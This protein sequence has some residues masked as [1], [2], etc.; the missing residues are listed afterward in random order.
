[1]IMEKALVVG[2]SGLLGGHLI[3]AAKNEYEVIATFKDHP[4]EIGGCR[5]VCLDITDRNKTEKVIIKEKPDLIILTAAQ[6]NVDY[7]EK[8]PDEAGKVNAEGA[9]NV[10]VAS[11]KVHAK[12]IYLSTDLVFDG[13]KT[14]YVEDDETHPV[15]HYGRTKL[16]GE[17]E[18]MNACKDAAIARVSVLYGWNIFDHTFNFVAWVY[19]NLKQ[20]KKLELFEDQFRNATYVKNACHALLNIYKNDEKG[21]YHVVGKN[22]VNRYYIGMKV[23]EIFEL[24]ENL[25]TSCDSDESDW[26]AKR[27]KRCCLDPEKMEKKLDIESMSLEEGLSAMRAEKE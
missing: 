11:E 27:P 20:G 4:F 2:G 18:V 22:C 24:D 5:N 12:L 13:T 25:I 17:Q 16:E 3:E 14:S 23:A 26:F 6:R 15:N 21:V 9:R 19:D 7:C 8:N 10:A 1:M